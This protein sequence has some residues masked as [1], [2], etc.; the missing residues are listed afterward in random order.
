MAEPAPV[1]YD[2]DVRV[3]T[4]ELFFDLV[5]VFT[6]TQLTAALAHDPTWEGLLRVVLMLFV[7]WWMYAAFAWLTNALPP[8]S[9]ARRLFL[10][11]G[12]AGFLVISLA[13]PTAFAGDGVV[14]GAAYLVVVCFHTGLFVGSAAWATLGDVLR[15]TRFNILTAILIIVAGVVG[16]DAWEYLLWGL[17]V[18]VIFVTPRF[19]RT[20][21]DPIR[22]SSHFVERHGLVVIVALGES[23]VAVGIGASGQAL[24]VEMLAVAVLGLALSAGLWWTYFGG[25]QDEPRRGLDAAPIE[26]RAR[27]A[28]NAYFFSHLLILLGIVAIAVAEEEAIAHAF[29]P[30]AF[31]L[32]LALGGGAAVFLAGDV[33]FRRSL[34][35][36]HGPWRPAAA[37]LALASIPL[38]TEGSALLQLAALVF[39]I[40]ACLVAERLVE[41]VKS[42]QD[43]S[44]GAP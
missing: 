18:I 37:G 34:G 44:A 9:S 33:L 19:A 2:E 14:F 32:A 26:R 3:S 17:A 29:D 21:A 30:L 28:L 5:F 7:I 24:S 20:E 36:G 6:I 11:G 15:F 41:E 4:L 22:S 10:L 40:A 8:E 13:I 25:D 39:A 23:V 12:M 1:T 35:I 38:G 43:A 27:V 16:E 42:V 31:A